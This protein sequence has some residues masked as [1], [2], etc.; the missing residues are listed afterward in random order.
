MKNTILIVEDE[1]FIADLLRMNLQA[2][3]YETYM[4]CD[5][6]RAEEMLGTCLPTGSGAGGYHVTGKSWV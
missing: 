1:R 3:G 5:G 6:V 2:A 4:A